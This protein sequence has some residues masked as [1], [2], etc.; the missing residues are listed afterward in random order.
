MVLDKIQFLRM[1]QHTLVIG[2]PTM[3]RFEKGK[4]Q[5]DNLNSN[6]NSFDG[7]VYC[8]NLN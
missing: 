4:F 1:D 7:F 2:E 3:V 6:M 8:Y 5:V